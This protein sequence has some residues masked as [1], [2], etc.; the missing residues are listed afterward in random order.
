MNQSILDAFSDELEK[1]AALSTK[2]KAIIL[3]ITFGAAGIGG[4]AIGAGA[5]NVRTI[6]EL[7][8][9]RQQRKIATDTKGIRALME[10]QAK[11]KSDS[12]QQ[13]IKVDPYYNLP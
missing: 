7:D 9:W 2:Q 4:L 13:A 5:T 10:A 8:R 12:V 6:G 3:G 1:T 11:P